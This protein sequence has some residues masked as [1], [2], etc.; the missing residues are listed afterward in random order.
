MEEEGL[1]ARED[2]VEGGKVRKYYV[3]TEKGLKE[4]SYVRR[5]ISELYHEVVE[6][7]GRTTSRVGALTRRWH[8]LP[9]GILISPTFSRACL[10]TSI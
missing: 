2:R 8:C 4:L 5:M 9:P 10:A 1:L 7:R 6:R 3:A